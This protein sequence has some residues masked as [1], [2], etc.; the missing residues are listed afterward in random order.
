MVTRRSFFLS[1]PLSFSLLGQVGGADDFLMQCTKIFNTNVGKD[2]MARFLKGEDTSEAAKLREV[3]TDAELG[4][5][6]GDDFGAAGADDYDAPL[7]GQEDQEEEQ[8]QQQTQ[9]APGGPP[10]SSEGGWGDIIGDEDP[11]QLLREQQEAEE[12]L[13]QQEA[14]LMAEY[15]QQYS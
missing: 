2:N 12:L 15:E 10:P 14:E 3:M 8:T 1:L 4:E 7:D 5:F 9:Q 6:A 11:D 13:A